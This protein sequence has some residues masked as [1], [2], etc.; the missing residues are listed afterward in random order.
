M[1]NA[2]YFSI[3]DRGYAG[4]G[5]NLMG[6][7][8]EFWEYYPAN[9]QWTRKADFMSTER[10]RAAGMS[11][12]SFGYI[13]AGTTPSSL[14]KDFF[15]Y[16]PVSD[17]WIQ[18]ADFAGNRRDLAVAFR[19]DDK[20]YIGLGRDA[21]TYYK[22]FWEYDP[23]SNSWAQKADLPSRERIGAIGFGIGNRGYVGLGYDNVG[24]YRKDVYR[25]SPSSN[26]WLRI[27]KDFPGQGRE[28]AV[29][30][31]VDETGKGYVMC[32]YYRLSTYLRD[33]WEFDKNTELFTKIASFPVTVPGRSGA[34]GFVIN[35]IAYLGLGKDSLGNYLK[36]FW[37]YE[38]PTGMPEISHDRTR[39]F[40]NPVSHMLTITTDAKQAV[41]SLFDL[42]GKKIM[43][44]AIT[45]GSNAIPVT[46][47]PSGSYLYEIRGATANRVSAGKV[48]KLN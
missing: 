11:I 14:R 20:G 45:A 25:Y 1:E 3:G 46:A 29:C 9:D 23:S 19:I 10:S 43:E 40:P 13:G 27:T 35:G 15:Q 16:D 7:L 39:L 41:F 24:E 22:D 28:Q 44:T 26:G 8:N 33:C 5:N 4:T 21:S 42:H 38:L 47:I 32:G 36:D 48:M 6:F 37:A 17:S 31:G 2:V 18:K 34:V 30:F 12:G